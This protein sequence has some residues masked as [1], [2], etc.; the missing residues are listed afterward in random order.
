[1]NRKRDQCEATLWA[2]T[3]CPLCPHLPGGGPCMHPAP[4][5]GGSETPRVHA[6]AWVECPQ[7]T[8]EP[9]LR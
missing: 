7:R 9:P 2:G 5:V 1:M 6:W 8:R 4:A 3:M